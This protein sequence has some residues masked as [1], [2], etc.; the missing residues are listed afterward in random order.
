M[1][2]SSETVSAGELTQKL[3][4]NGCGFFGSPQTRDLCS[5]CYKDLISR[6]PA[7]A[8]VTSLPNLSTEPVPLTN[9]PPTESL[10]PK[11]GRCVICDKSVGYLVIPCR[12]ELTVC[13]K[14]RMPEDHNCPFDY[15]TT[16]SMVS[17]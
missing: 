15:K 6:E 13:R 11:L 16:R 7:N 5:R 4:N 3:C 2:E 12:C 8:E 14:H 17:S 1:G 10:P 9:E